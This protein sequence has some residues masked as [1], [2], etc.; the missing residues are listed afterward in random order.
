MGGKQYATWGYSPENQAKIDSYEKEWQD[1]LESGEYTADD[2]QTMR[3]ELDARIENV[4]KSVNKRTNVPD[5]DAQPIYSQDGRFVWDASKGVNGAWTPAPADRNQERTD[6]REA[7]LNERKDKYVQSIIDKLMEPQDKYIEGTN[8]VNPSEK[9]P[10]MSFEDAL[11]EAR[12][13]SDAFFAK[14][15]EAAVEEPEEPVECPVCGTM[16]TGEVCPQCNY[17]WGS[18]VATEEEAPPAPT[19]HLKQSYL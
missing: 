14:P 13:R 19:G 2:L 4:K 3:D 16:F 5:V 15:E 10:G 6:A 18:A 11:K 17:V 8:M 1:M 9:L 12:R 7:K